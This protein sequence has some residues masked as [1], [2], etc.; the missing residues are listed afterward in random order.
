MKKSSIIYCCLLLIFLSACKSDNPLNDEDN[1]SN[2]VIQNIVG[3]VNID[4]LMVYV[5]QLSGVV[6]V[7]V[8][9]KSAAITTRTA[10]TVG[11][12]TARLFL[13]EKLKSYGLDVQIQSFTGIGTGYNI[14]AVQK[15]TKYPGKKYILCAHYDSYSTSA[16]SP[17]ADDNGSGVAAVIEA[18]RIISKYKPQYTIVYA[19]WDQEE[20]GLYGS[21]Y[22]ANNSAAK[23]DSIIG[24][25]NMDMIGYDGNNDKKCWV[26]A[27]DDDFSKSMADEIINNNNIYKIG[28]NPATVIPAQ[29]ESDQKS[30]INAGFS[31][32]CIDEDFWSDYDLQLHTGNDIINYFSSDYFFGCSKLV[33]C[34]IASI[35]IVE[36]P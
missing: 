30:F 9:G 2:P 34:S 6:S 33:I 14:L 15:G 22:Y 27:G 8:D 21:I 35:A 31:A 4:S 28:L 11:H 29:A 19:L 16:I 17:G 1:S 26:Q 5:K 23:K 32:V 36:N 25:I 12:T 20:P 10:G 18:A 24:V 13:T 3:N 7:N